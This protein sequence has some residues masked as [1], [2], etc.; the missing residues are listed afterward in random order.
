MTDEFDL[1]AD[2]AELE[3]ATA[4]ANHVNRPR[5]KLHVEQCVDC[6]TPI[7]PQRIEWGA[8]RCVPCES[9]REAARR[10]PR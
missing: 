7:S 2:R 5:P 4:V 1:A 6:A 10:V 9:E 8:V 3:R